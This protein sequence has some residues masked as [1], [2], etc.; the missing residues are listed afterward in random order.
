MLSLFHSA[1]A[2]TLRG[3][4]GSQVLTFPSL[5]RPMDI[6]SFGPFGWFGLHFVTD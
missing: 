6:N 3:R 1:F 4:N 5:D 2:S